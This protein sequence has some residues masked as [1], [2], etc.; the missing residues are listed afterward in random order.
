MTQIVHGV[1]SLVQSLSRKER[2]EL[3][4]VMLSP[5]MLAED[6]QDACVIASRRQGRRRA[7]SGFV[8][9]NPSHYPSPP[10][11]RGQ[12]EEETGIL[13]LPQHIAGLFVQEL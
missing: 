8:N 9:E 12:G 13:T 5:E 7:L 1:L 11:G 4:G 6:Q 2:K 10:R 3:L